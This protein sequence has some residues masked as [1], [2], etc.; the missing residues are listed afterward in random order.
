VI[1]KS[2]N[3]DEFFYYEDVPVQYI[4]DQLMKGV[5][6]YFVVTLEFGLE[7]IYASSDPLAVNR[8]HK[9]DVAGANLSTGIHPII[10]KYSNGEL[11]DEHHVLEDIIPEWTEQDVHVLP[12]EQ[13]FDK[14]LFEVGSHM[15]AN[16]SEGSSA[17]SM[18]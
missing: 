2:T 3:G 6:E 5:D 10:K 1:T 7:I 13:F 14:S 4:H 16:A 17:G 12:L 11:K 18:M 15:Y 8:I 9:D